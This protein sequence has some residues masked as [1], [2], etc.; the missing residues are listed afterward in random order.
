MNLDASM[1][2]GDKFN[3]RTKREG[4]SLQNALY[5]SALTV[6]ALLGQFTADQLLGTQF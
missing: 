6:T 5:F 3:S 4:I 2:L 1:E